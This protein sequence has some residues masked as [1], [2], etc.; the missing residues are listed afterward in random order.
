M[1]ALSSRDQTDV[2]G[3][4]KSKWD[5]PA[6]LIVLSPLSFIYLYIQ[7]RKRKYKVFAILYA[8]PL[9]LFFSMLLLSPTVNHEGFTAVMVMTGISC[10]FSS[11]ISF[12]HIS[13]VKNEFGEEI[14]KA[15]SKREVELVK[16]YF[17]DDKEIIR[18]WLISPFISHYKDEQL[19]RNWYITIN[20]LLAFLVFFFFTHPYYYFFPGNEYTVQG[21]L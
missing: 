12:F 7:L 17:S 8:I 9:F 4:Q 20:S 11:L 10:F 1:N 6:K 21:V 14:N 3:E 19:G 13:R 15:A 18:T 16:K 2:T 5:I